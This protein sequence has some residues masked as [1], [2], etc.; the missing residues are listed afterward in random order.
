MKQHNFF[1]LKLLPF[2]SILFFM[3]NGCE[4]KNSKE[5]DIVGEWSAYWETKADESIPHKNGDNL[6][7]DGRIKFMENGKVE[8]VAFGYEGCIFSDDTLTNTLNWKLDEK[9]LRFID[10]GDE[11]GLPYTIQKY[12]DHELQLTLLE[13]INLTLRRN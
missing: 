1:K 12:T 8:I 5:M 11:N 3:M 2:I 13:D 6:K 9:V 10:N 4:V 7:M